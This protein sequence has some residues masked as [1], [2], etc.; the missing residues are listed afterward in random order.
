VN[1]DTDLEAVIAGAAG[2]NLKRVGIATRWNDWMND[3]LCAYLGTAGIEVVAVASS[4]RSMEENAAL[5][6]ATGIKLA[7]DL[8]DRLLTEAE[9]EGVIMPGGRW[10]TVGAVRA[11]EA[12]H[13]KPVITNHTASLWTALK[14]AGHRDPVVGWGRL[15]S[16]LSGPSR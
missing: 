5:D 14:A 16:D 15:L 1:A 7:K 10:I 11:L 3:R 12:K 6:D 2:L 4:G 13:G 9:V 8:G